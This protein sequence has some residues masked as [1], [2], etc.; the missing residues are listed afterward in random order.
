MPPPEETR[1]TAVAVL[2]TGIM[3]AP[4]ARNLVATGFDVRAWNRSAAKAAAL[5]ETGVTVAATPG[6]AADGADVLVT[7]LADG[8]AVAAVVTHETAPLA[9]L[10]D[11][12]FWIQASTVGI[13]W[14]DR[15]AELARAAGVTFLDAPVLG[16]RGPAEQGTLTILAGGPDDA[17]DRCGPV[18]DAIGSRVHRLGAAG[19]ASRMKLVL[20]AWIVALVTA[21]GEAVAL[22]E[23]LGVD[24]AGFL[25]IIDG[26]PI[27]PAYARLKGDL[28]TA[29]DFPPSFPLEL[30]LK[31]ARLVADAAETLGLE[32]PV[33]AAV[34]R[35]MQAADAG[36]HGRE[37]MAAVVAA[38]RENPRD[39]G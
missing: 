31:D 5:A 2:G 26:G 36:G 30:A 22:A 21:L 12:A 20:N 28:M 29:G 15:L 32:V 39:G 11:N 3:G 34:I 35:Q 24:P 27:G 6:D 37:D 25:D 23:R 16:T 8:P 1:V 38:Y 18:F 19:A 13:D 7:M 4:I 9:R 14:V 17:I 10:A 33:I